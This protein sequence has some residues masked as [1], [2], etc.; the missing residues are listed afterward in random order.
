MSSEC[1]L[2]N[3][4]FLTLF[5]NRLNHSAL[6]IKNSSALNIVTQF[7]LAYIAQVYNH[8]QLKDIAS[9]S[10]TAPLRVFQ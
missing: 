5:S 10:A 2:Q 6:T 4:L 7:M 1:H 3:A 9:H 8:D